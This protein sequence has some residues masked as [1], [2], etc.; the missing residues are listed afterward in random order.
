LPRNAGRVSAKNAQGKN[1]LDDETSNEI[2][3]LLE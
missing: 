2:N 1:I 3:P